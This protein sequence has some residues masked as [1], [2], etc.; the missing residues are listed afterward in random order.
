MNGSYF[1]DRPFFHTIIAIAVALT[2]TLAFAQE[3]P[4]ASNAEEVGMSSKRLERINQVARLQRSHE[5]G[6]VIGGLS[7][8][9]NVFAWFSW[10][11]RCGRWRHEHRVDNVHHAVRGRNVSCD[12]L[13]G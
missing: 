12:D 10:R 4:W 3:I 5:R 11:H 2:T 9:N 6:Q 7:E 8:L 1:S 13:R